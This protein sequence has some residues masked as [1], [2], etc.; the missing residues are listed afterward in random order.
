MKKATKSSGWARGVCRRVYYQRFESQGVH[1]LLGGV[2]AV[3]L[4]AGGILPALLLVVIHSALNAVWFSLMIL[5][6]GYFDRA[7]AHVLFQRIMRG[8]TGVAL[9]GFGVALAVTVF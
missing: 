2:S 8:I 4:A 7:G 6:F 1:V 3:Y 9:L 5:F